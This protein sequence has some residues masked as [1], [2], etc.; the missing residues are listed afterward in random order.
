MV[1]DDLPYGAPSIVLSED[2][3]ATAIQLVCCGAQ[4]A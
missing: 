1:T 4:D 3:I 2:H